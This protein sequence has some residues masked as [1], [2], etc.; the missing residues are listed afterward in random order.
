[1]R[2]AVRA[3]VGSSFLSGPS[4]SDDEVARSR[5]EDA[6]PAAFF[7]FFSSLSPLS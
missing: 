7:A 5:E 4:S 6:D 3:A 2:P 1:M